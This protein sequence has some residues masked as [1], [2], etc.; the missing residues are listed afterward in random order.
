MF[1]WHCADDAE[2]HREQLSS[3][4]EVRDKLEREAKEAKR[5]L[6]VAKREAAV[7]QEKLDGKREHIMLQSKHM[8]QVGAVLFAG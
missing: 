6:A 2:S 4:V 7:L 5:Q 8:T 1:A 3:A